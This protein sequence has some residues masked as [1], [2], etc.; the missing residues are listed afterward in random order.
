MIPWHCRRD[1]SRAI[2]E[3]A[4]AAVAVPALGTKE[5]LRVAEVTQPLA[6]KSSGV[7]VVRD[8]RGGELTIAGPALAFSGWTICRHVYQ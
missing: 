1:L 7:E 6:V 8:H 4:V 3:H 2:V 5:S